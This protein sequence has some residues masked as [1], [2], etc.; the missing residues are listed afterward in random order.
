MNGV[1]IKSA[2]KFMLCSSWFMDP[3]SSF[4]SFEHLKYIYVKDSLHL[5]YFWFLRNKCLSWPLTVSL[6]GGQMC[7]VYLVSS[8]FSWGIMFCKFL[9]VL[10]YR[11]I[12]N[13]FL[14]LSLLGPSGVLLL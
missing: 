4:I 5:D 11:C 14:W 12:P 7:S 8:L 6:G 10:D 2:I 13:P 3:M 9:S 1:Y